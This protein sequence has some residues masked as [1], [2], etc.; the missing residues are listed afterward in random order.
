MEV[1]K[2]SMSSE[3]NYT[4]V[5]SCGLEANVTVNLGE[6]SGDQTWTNI[7]VTI[8]DG[9]AVEPSGFRIVGKGTFERE[10]LLDIFE[11]LAKALK[12]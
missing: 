3:T 2:G 7:M 11:V 9:A 12:E 6:H 4:L 10:L 8:G 1:P 5:S